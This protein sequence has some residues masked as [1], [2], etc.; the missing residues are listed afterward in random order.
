MKAFIETM[1]TVALILLQLLNHKV[2]YNRFLKLA[3][4]QQKL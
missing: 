2:F 3:G 4:L 1:C